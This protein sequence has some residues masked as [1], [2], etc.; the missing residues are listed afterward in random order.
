[1]DDRL[2]AILKVEAIYHC[3]LGMAG[4]RLLKR[5]YGEAL[6]PGVI[7]YQ[8]NMWFALQGILSIGANL[9]ELFWGRKAPRSK[10][11]VRPCGGLPWLMTARR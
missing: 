8:D 2:L 7:R 4:G 11:N 10:R 9:A 5:S 6:D 3:Q 1:M